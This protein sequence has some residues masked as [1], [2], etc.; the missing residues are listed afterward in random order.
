MS[1][2]RDYSPEYSSTEPKRSRHPKREPAAPH[3]RSRYPE[4]SLEAEG[5]QGRYADP[6]PDHLLPHKGKHR[7]P[8]YVPTETG[9]SHTVDSERVVRRKERLARPPPPHSPRDRGTDWDREADWDRKY[10]RHERRGR[11][12]E[13]SYRDAEWSQDRGLSADR[14]QD[15]E[16]HRHKDPHRVRTRSRDRVLDEDYD[17]VSPSWDRPRRDRPSWEEEEV[18]QEQRARGRRR[19]E[20]NPDDVFEEQSDRRRKE[21]REPWESQHWEGPTRE[22]GHSHPNTET[23][24]TRSR[25]F[26][27][28][29]G[30]GLWLYWFEVVG[31][32]Q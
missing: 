32:S 27:L 10:E 14:L 13:R 17:D 12:E 21:S 4:H 2:Y 24:S 9:R 30:K 26:H 22:R 25:L 23:G 1:P 20:S 18:E 6:Y 8:D 19:V 3:S 28:V 7:Y 29:C 31:F 5:S 15:R 11:Q 16:R